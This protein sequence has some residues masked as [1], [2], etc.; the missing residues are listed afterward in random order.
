MAHTKAELLREIELLRKKGKKSEKLRQQLSMELE[1][2]R[3]T[4]M[5][6]GSF[7]SKWPEIASV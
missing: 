4:V 3:K 2:L 6:T 7:G 1:L 5:K